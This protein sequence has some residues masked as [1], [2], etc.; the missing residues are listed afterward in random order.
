MTVYSNSLLSTYE[1]C[2]LKYKL[3]YRDRIKRKFETVEGFLGTMVHWTLR[4]CYDDHR[5][6]V[7]MNMDGLLSH[8]NGLWKHR[9]NDSII[10]MKKDKTSEDYKS[11][12]E[13]MLGDYYRHYS[14]FNSDQTI[15]TELSI[16]FFLDD[17]HKYRMIGYID[18]LSKTSDGIIQIHDFKTSANLPN[19]NDADTD[20]QLALYQLGVQQKWPDYNTI[21]LIWHYLAFDM[22]LVSLRSPEAICELA[23]NTMS[24]IDEIESTQE[25]PPRE[26]GLCD[27]CEYP[28]LCPIRKNIVIKES[29]TKNEYDSQQ[30]VILV[31]RFALLN[32]RG[33]GTEGEMEKVKIELIEYALREGIDVIRGNEYQV[34]ITPVN[35]MKIRGESDIESTE[36]ENIIHEVGKWAK[37]FQNDITSLGAV[38]DNNLW[39]NELMEQ[40]MKYSNDEKGYSIQISRPGN[41]KR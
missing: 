39:S 16:S 10:I 37:V 12:G 9:W 21:H 18:R 28:D 2:P 22:E 38:F 4:K 34:K 19:Q 29:F 5:F 6:G 26:S 35:K 15:D 32:N 20:R 3:R 30:G 25:F 17:A 41:L 8:F 23:W 11:R 40:I 36:L 14:P 1:Q 27:W 24:L 7:N 13:E 33:E 31:D